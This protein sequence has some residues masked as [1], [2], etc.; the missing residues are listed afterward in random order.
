MGRRRNPVEGTSDVTG[1]GRFAAAALGAC[2]ILLTAA[3]ERPAPSLEAQV[4]DRINF[5][6]EHPREYAA[7]LRD[8]RRYF[9]GDLLYLPGDPYGMITHE[10]TD[11]V[12]EAIDFLERQAPLPALSHG[13]LLEL[14]AQDHAA[15]QG[16]IAGR[17]HLSPDGA[18]PGERV[19][20]RGGD[21]YV[22]EGI[23]YGYNRADEVVRQLIVDDGVRDRG[24]RNLLFNGDFRYAGVGCGGHSQYGHMCVV[25]MSSTV[26]GAPRRQQWA[27]NGQAYTVRAAATR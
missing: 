12:D 4:L 6:R 11:A 22:G 2:W 3:N 13:D 24:H 26:N 10:G 19:R 16:P 14:A 9:N 18:S 5:A 15:E 1:P 7:Q 25:D 8:Y 20:R 21:I 17:G 27:S 23:S